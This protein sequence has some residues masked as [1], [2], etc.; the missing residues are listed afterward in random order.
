MRWSRALLVAIVTAVM[1]VPPAALYRPV[2]ADT[3]GDAKVSRPELI[4]EDAEKA[5][6]RGLAYLASTQSRD[7]AW[8][9]ANGYGSYPCAM[10]SLAGLALL[11]AGNTTVEGEYAPKVRLAVKYILSCANRNGVISRMDEEQNCMHSH[12]FAMLFLAQAYGMER[13]ESQRE[14][15]R[16]VLVAAVALTGQSQSRD[17]GW[18]YTPE[19]GDD[20]GS[21]TVTQIQGLRAIRNAGIKVPKA[22]I[23]RA[24]MYIRK[25]ANADGGIRYKVSGGGSDSRPAI[26]A[27]A[28]ATLYN[29]GEYEDK[30]AIGALAYCKKMLKDS[31]GAMINTGHEYYTTLYLSQAMYLSGAENWDGYFPR[32]RDDLIRKQQSNGAWQGDGVG[33]TY[34]TAIALL[35]LQL[36]YKY[37]PILQR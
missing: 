29:A 35:T 17:G 25:S 6:R 12:G 22:I 30:V 1:L 14:K 3:A 7:G 20:E 32:V 19:S 34:G 37:L 15:I 10:T 2:V 31:G 36:P 5:I 18:F 9:N 24:A 23:E 21:V 33:E 28:V 8:R 26:T 13:D 16:K 11:A 27:A 4:T